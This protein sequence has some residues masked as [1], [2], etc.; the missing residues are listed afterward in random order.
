MSFTTEVVKNES[1]VTKKQIENSFNAKF[2]DFSFIVSIQQRKSGLF[3]KTE[4]QHLCGGSIISEKSILTAAHCFF[5]RSFNE[6]EYY[7][8]GGLT[9]LNYR[10]SN[11]KKIKNCLLHPKYNEQYMENDIAIVILKNKFT[12]T[13]VLKS[14][15]YSYEP[16]KVWWTCFAI[17]FR[18]TDE[19]TNYLQVVKQRICDMT[20]C[21]KHFPFILNP[22]Q[23]ICAR[24]IVQE[25]VCIG[26]S[27]GPFIC[28]GL[29][30]G[31]VPLSGKKCGNGIPS[32]YVSIA[33]YKNWISR[34]VFSSYGM[35]ILQYRFANRNEIIRCILHP[36][37]DNERVNNDLA[38][39]IIRNRFY[40]SK[41]TKPVEY[42]DTPIEEFK[43]CYV[44]GFGAINSEGTVQSKYLLVLRQDVL[45]I[46]HCFQSFPEWFEGEH[47]FCAGGIMGRD[48]CLGDSGGPFICNDK[49]YGVVSY[50]SERCAVGNPTVFCHV[51]Y[52]KNWI[53]QEII[54]LRNDGGSYITVVCGDISLYYKWK[55]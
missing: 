9:D 45:N 10:Y 40:Y 43:G 19:N 47:Q 23:G 37:Y 42:S 54:Q 3:F 13:N 48:T 39:G 30:H 27:G 33:Y 50:G 7:A 24:E 1:G 22:D 8:V 25:D 55:D 28:Y 29:L 16:A 32:Y 31:I 38:L 34:Q 41:G 26:D 5:N 6:Y 11:R 18:R 46:K 51:P 52:Y 2:D 20:V 14:V 4:L 15:T 17:G 49:L 35:M 53:K 44:M 12:F 36:N 21:V